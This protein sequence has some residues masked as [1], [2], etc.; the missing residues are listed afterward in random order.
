MS[1]H[2]KTDYKYYRFA[3]EILWKVTYQPVW[4][5]Q[6]ERG[7]ATFSKPH[8]TRALKSHLKES[9]TRNWVSP[10]D[11]IVKIWLRFSLVKSGIV[12]LVIKVYALVSNRTIKNWAVDIC[13][14]W[15]SVHKNLFLFLTPSPLPIM[16]QWAIKRRTSW[17]FCF[18][19][20]FS[21][22]SSWSGGHYRRHYLQKPR[23]KT[24]LKK[25]DKG[26]C[27]YRRHGIVL[28]QFY[29]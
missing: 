15:V 26:Q 19:S 3:L 29:F 13:C 12:G 10:S 9:F 28:S 24:K 6:N 27:I 16:V 23:C 11:V 5:V 22:C 1:V 14:C 17:N 21:L 4:N 8:P 20:N 7:T 2:T 18:T 25:V